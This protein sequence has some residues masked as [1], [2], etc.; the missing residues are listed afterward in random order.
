MISIRQQP[1]TNLSKVLPL[2]HIRTDGGTQPRA[3]LCQDVIDEYAEAL[4][5]GADFPPVILFFDGVQYWLAD[6]FHRLAAARQTGQPSIIADIRPGTRRE[7]VLHSVGANA[8]HGLRRTNADKRR[9]VTTLLTDLEW[10][11]WSDREIA[12]QC[13]VSKTFVNHMRQEVNLTGNGCQSKNFTNTSNQEIAPRPTWRRG[14]DGRTIDTSNIGQRNAS[15]AT[16]KVDNKPTTSIE[17]LPRSLPPGP[18]A[19]TTPPPVTIDVAA[20][21]I[22]MPEASSEVGQPEALL[23]ENRGPAPEPQ[24]DFGEKQPQHRM[25]G[26]V[27]EPEGIA[28]GD[29]VPSVPAVIRVLKIEPADPTLPDDLV[30]VFEIIGSRG[31]RC[32]IE[33][34]TGPVIS[35]FR[36]LQKQP[37][38]A[39]QAIRQ[40]QIFA[41]DRSV[42]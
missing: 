22:H 12:R 13:C 11:V 24:L 10:S 2:S 37:I 16:N 34:C 3:S 19:E 8:A 42:G 6:G 36:Q 7:A 21:T 41:R 32:Q 40:L 1:A 33:A 15:T 20:E 27:D 28:S 35:L 31:T 5:A 18:Q 38:A 39:A 4:M 14:A 29:E 17:V 30:E 9:A 23:E 25:V 26:R